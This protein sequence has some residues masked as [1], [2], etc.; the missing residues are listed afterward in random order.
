[1][2]DSFA[3][4]GSDSA[5]MRD[6]AANDSNGAG[7]LQPRVK[8]P[9]V[10]TVGASRRLTWLLVGLSTCLIVFLTAEYFVERIYFAST[11][12]RLRAEMEVAAEALETLGLDQLSN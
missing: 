9:A 2:A 4:P 1:M 12:G 11:R 5:E 10:D 7:L 8:A 3:S 6:V